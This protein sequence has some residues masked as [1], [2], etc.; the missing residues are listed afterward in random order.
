[1]LRAAECCR[2]C[3]G[4]TAGKRGLFTEE[5]I[6]FDLAVKGGLVRIIID[7]GTRFGCVR[8]FRISIFEFSILTHFY[9]QRCVGTCS[10]RR[11]VAPHCCYDLSTWRAC[12]AFRESGND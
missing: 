4:D 11:A 12:W 10:S 5:D 1:M 8:A 2:L 6:G 9:V 3:R 7:E